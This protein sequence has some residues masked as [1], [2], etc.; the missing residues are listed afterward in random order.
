MWKVSLAAI[1][2]AGRMMEKKFAKP[3]FTVEPWPPQRHTW[4]I[5]SGEVV[6][7]GVKNG[8][9]ARF[10]A[11]KGHMRTHGQWREFCDDDA[12]ERLSAV[13]R[14]IQAANPGRVIYLGF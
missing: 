6:W 5:D 10:E 13:C 3:L 1:A 7:V 8:D 14:D 2:K 12:Y 11:V 4:P 9:I